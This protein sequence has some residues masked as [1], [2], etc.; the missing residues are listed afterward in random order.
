MRQEGVFQRIG[1]RRDAVLGTDAQNRSVQRIKGFGHDA[2]RDLAGVATDVDT[3]AG[4]HAA[5]GLAHRGEDR[6]DVQRHQ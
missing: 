3:M 5:A 6:L 4:N 2:R 1:L